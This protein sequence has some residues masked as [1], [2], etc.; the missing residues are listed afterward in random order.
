MPVKLFEGNVFEV[1]G[2]VKVNAVNNQGVSGAG[3]AKAVKEKFPYVNDFYL[4]NYKGKR[5]G[6]I[7]FD[8]KHLWVHAFTKEDWRDYSSE[9]W[10]RECLSNIR[11]LIDEKEIKKI[12][13][14]MLG[15]GLGGIQQ[16]LFMELIYEIYKDTPEDVEVNICLNTNNKM[17]K[18]ITG[19]YYG[20]N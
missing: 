15:C 18:K 16:E 17:I 14:P 2:G 6:D 4:N 9:T 19:V 8:E 3:L 5:G 11:K 10:V 7:I 1:K 12:S 20:K 13:I